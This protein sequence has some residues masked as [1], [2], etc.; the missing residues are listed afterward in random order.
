LLNKEV[1]LAVAD[2]NKWYPV[3]PLNKEQTKK[4]GLVTLESE[5]VGTISDIKSFEVIK[6]SE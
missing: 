2:D 5:F 6:V 4:I 1:E 3:K